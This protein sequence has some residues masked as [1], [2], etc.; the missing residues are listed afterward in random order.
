MRTRPRFRELGRWGH[1]N[2]VVEILPPPPL[3]LDLLGPFR[4][5]FLDWCIPLQVAPE[6]VASAWAGRRAEPVRARRDE[7]EDGLGEE[8]LQDIFHLAG[9]ALAALRDEDVPVEHPELE[10]RGAGPGLGGPALAGLGT[11]GAPGPHPLR[12]SLSSTPLLAR[13]LFC[14]VRSLGLRMQASRPSDSLVRV[15]ND[16]MDASETFGET[17]N[18]IHNDPGRELYLL[19]KQACPAHH[20]PRFLRELPFL[21]I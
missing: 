2:A 9:P 10:P 11:S 8:G 4:C 3:S 6:V 1:V 15:Q 7:F 14:R 20:F 18:G 12:N 17:S 5:C 21:C 16:R 19:G 13:G